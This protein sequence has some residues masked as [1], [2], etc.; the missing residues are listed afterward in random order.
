MLFEVGWFSYPILKG[1]YPAVM[2]ERID[3]NS[4]NEGRPRSRLPVF[5]DEEVKFINGTA[6]FMGVNHYSTYYARIP[7]Y[8]VGP[9]PSLERDCGV[10]T[11]Q[12]EA[13][14]PSASDWL[15]VVPWG[16]RRQV[17]WYKKHFNNIPVFVTENG[18][19]DR[20]EVDD[21]N[22]INYYNGYLHE[23]LNAIY[24]DGCNVMGYTAWSLMDNFEWMK[25]Y[26]ERFG[27]YKVDY[28]DP[29]R[30]R[31]PKASVEFFKQVLSTRTL[32]PLESTKRSD[33]Y[34][35]FLK[36]QFKLKKH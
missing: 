31:S 30:A 4:K 16:I 19:S 24:E 5:T 22:R 29:N 9:D 25:G 36:D 21:L 10:E 32:P 17:N 23:L 6:D 3:A 34:K 11:W 14:P 35:V 27:I 7:P 12:D 2:R 18:F 33:E 8:D 15:K 26:S 20:G 1:D 13:W 28:D